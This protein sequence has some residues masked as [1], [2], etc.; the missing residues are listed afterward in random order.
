M[1]FIFMLDLGSQCYIIDRSDLFQKN[2]SLLACSVTFTSKFLKLI[3]RVRPLYFCLSFPSPHA[4]PLCNSP[5][6]CSI[7]VKHLGDGKHQLVMSY[8]QM[9]YNGAIEAR[10]PT[11]RG[12]DMATCQCNFDVI[13]GEEA[14]QIG[15]CGDVT[16][17]A[18]K[19]CNWSI[20]YQVRSRKTF[21]RLTLTDPETCR[22]V[23]S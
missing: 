15:D 11:N 9:S 13:K 1:I 19:D 10:T 17:I 3:L 8:I 7:E 14:P 18:N 16:G 20:P 23:G 12:N 22:H 5:A 4:F 21:R 6:P 2:S